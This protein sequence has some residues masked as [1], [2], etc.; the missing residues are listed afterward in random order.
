MCQREPAT[1]TRPHHSRHGL[2]R[3]YGAGVMV[4]RLDELQLSMFGT[5]VWMETFGRQ[6]RARKLDAER[7]IEAAYHLRHALELVAMVRH[8]E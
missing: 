5:G 3:W 7:L 6:T 8:D 4:E 1:D 2:V